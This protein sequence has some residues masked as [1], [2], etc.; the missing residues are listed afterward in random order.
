MNEL[1]RSLAEQEDALKQAEADEDQEG[2]KDNQE[3]IDIIKA[4]IEELE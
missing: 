4:K 1:R 2:I 3:L